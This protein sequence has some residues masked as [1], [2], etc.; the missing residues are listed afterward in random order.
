MK[1]LGLPWIQAMPWGKWKESRP[2]GTD[3]YSLSSREAEPEAFWRAH[4]RSWV[5][6]AIRA[7]WIWQWAQFPGD[8]LNYSQW[9]LEYQGR[10]CWGHSPSVRQL[11]E[12]NPVLS[13]SNWA[14]GKI[15]TRKTWWTRL[16][17]SHFL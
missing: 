11:M 2:T 10:K 7:G 16:E 4:W 3:C 6:W 9:F 17:W 12:T 8:T 1:Y 13:A 5:S 14:E 15:G